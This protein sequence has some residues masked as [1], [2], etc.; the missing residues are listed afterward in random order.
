M[1]KINILWSTDNKHTID[2]LLAM[3]TIN[4]KAN[5]W[6]KNINVI[7]WGASA[8]LIG[9]EMKY[10]K[11]VKE[12]ID[13]GINVE[14]CKVCSDNFDAS[15]TLLELGVDVK[16]MGEQLTKYLKSDE[17]VLTI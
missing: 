10:Q 11:L 7:I 12:M 3:Y 5:G 1:D 9:A 15:N 4:S 8:K 17:K 6:W 14:A 13:S 16:S 2:N